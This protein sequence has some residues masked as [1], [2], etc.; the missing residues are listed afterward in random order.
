MSPSGDINNRAY[1][2][3]LKRYDS[4]IRFE[5]KRP[6]RRSLFISVHISL[7]TSLSVSFRATVIKC[8]VD[9]LL[10]C[11]RCIISRLY[12]CCNALSKMNEW[13]N[14]WMNELLP[15]CV[16]F[17]DTITCCR[18]ATRKL[19]DRRAVV[20]LPRTVKRNT[21]PDATQLDSWVASTSAVCRLRSSV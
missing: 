14:E 21:S 8:I 20:G 2:L 11:T 4:K 9:V 10:S 6:I 1:S 18:S 7:N 19:S 16:R 15:L 5:R 3:E 17:R 13:M 12:L